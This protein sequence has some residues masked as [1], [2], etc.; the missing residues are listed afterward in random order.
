MGIS[1]SLFLNIRAYVWTSRQGEYDAFTCPD[2]PPAAGRGGMAWPWPK[3]NWCIY[4]PAC[5]RHWQ[6]SE[7]LLT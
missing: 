2:P 1:A 3:I 4:G 5:T 7:I 6:Q